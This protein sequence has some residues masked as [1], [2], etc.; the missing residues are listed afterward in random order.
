MNILHYALG[1]PPYRSGGLT[2]YV[3]DL[4]LSQ[5]EYGNDVSLIWPGHYQ[6][7]KTRVSFVCHRHGKILN[8]EIINPLP[9]PLLAGIKDTQKYMTWGEKEIYLEFLEHIKPDILHVH[10]L[11]GLHGAMLEVANELHIPIIFTTH[12]YFGLCSKAN[13]YYNGEVC[14]NIDEQ[15]C[16]SCNAGA[17]SIAKVRLMQSEFYQFMK[18]PLKRLR[19]KQLFSKGSQ[20]TK[21]VAV[22]EPTVVQ[23]YTCEQYH[24]LAAFYRRLFE[25]INLF[26]FNSKLSRDI[27]EAFL[28]QMTLNGEVISISHRDIRDY[29]KIKVFPQKPRITFLGDGREH[30]GFALLIRVLDRLHHEGAKFSLTVYGTTDVE[31]DYLSV[32]GP[33]QYKDLGDIFYQTDILAVPS[34]WMETFGFVAVEA[35]TYGVPVLLSTHVGARDCFRHEV[36]SLIVE[37]LEEDLYQAFRQLMDDPRQLIEMNANIMKEVFMFS[38]TEHVK[39]MMKLYTR[40]KGVNHVSEEN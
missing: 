30:K 28:P 3:Y 9:V 17:F 22:D 29:R 11:M 21:D 12:D 39:E 18:E 13:L 8:Y 16:L 7:K 32:K 5:A 38:H 27:Y 19:F 36:D 14:K 26:H 33:Y 6:K 2:K 20:G 10:T 35:K 15:R 4:M 31:R 37:P 24:E 23:G 25:K 40:V 1:L 34:I